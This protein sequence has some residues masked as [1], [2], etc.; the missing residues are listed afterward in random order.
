MVFFPSL[1]L[2]LCIEKKDR[3]V[4]LSRVSPTSIYLFK[5]TAIQVYLSRPFLENGLSHWF[6]GTSI[7]VYLS[8]SFLKNVLSYW[9]CI[10]VYLLLKFFFF[11][12]V[13][14]PSPNHSTQFCYAVNSF[15]QHDF[16]F[17]Y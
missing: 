4:S 7:R 6:K 9:T 14:Y 3:S 16:F 12:E 8:R 13:C 15:F 2:S 5:G 1:S 11:Y 17:T 10:R